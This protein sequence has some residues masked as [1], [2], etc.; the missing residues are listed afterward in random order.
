MKTKLF[1]TLLVFFVALTSSY[2]SFPV[3]RTVKTETTISNSET[4]DVLDNSEVLLT[5]PAVAGSDDKWIGVALWAFLWPFAAHR[6][7]HGKPI[8]WNIL[9]IITL[10]GLGIWAIVDL[11][12]MLTDK[13]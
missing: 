3:E 7:F 11:I 8:G 6:W 4:V 12:N 9:F 13:F 2:A 10:G 5:S 1:L